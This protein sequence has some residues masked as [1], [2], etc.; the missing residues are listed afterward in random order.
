MPDY[1]LISVEEQH[2]HIAALRDLVA[3]A[4]FYGMFGYEECLD[5]LLRAALMR[6]IERGRATDSRWDD[7]GWLADEVGHSRSGATR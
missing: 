4:A 7:A 3:D 6:G 2:A 1:R 5:A